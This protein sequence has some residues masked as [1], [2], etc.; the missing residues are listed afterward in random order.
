MR[1]EKGH[2]AATHDNIVRIAAKSIRKKGL[3][4]TGIATLMADAGLTHG[5]FYAHF[6]SKDQLVDEAIAHAMDESRAL[7][8]RAADS[9]GGGLEPFIRAYLSP[10]HRDKPSLGCA[11]AALVAEVARRPIGLR[12]TLS[13]RMDMLTELIAQRLPGTAPI[14]SRRE[15]AR[16]VFALMVGTLQLA[17]AVPNKELSEQMLEQGVANALALAKSAK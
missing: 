3:E 17:R 10:L 1:Y 7:L 13:A 8:E 14:E 4:A 6:Q 15:T 12:K 5:A 16:G 11:V 2:K 9:E